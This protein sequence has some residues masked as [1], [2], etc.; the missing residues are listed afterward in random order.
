MESSS[1]VQPV[2]ALGFLMGFHVSIP[3]VGYRTRKFV[4]SQH[5]LL[6]VFALHHLQL[7]LNRLEPVISIHRLHSMR[8]GQ[9]LSALKI[10]KP[11]P[12]WRW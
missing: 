3:P 8:K 4:R 10:S 6:T 1:E 7:L 11:I 5:H 9:W 12:R 2:D